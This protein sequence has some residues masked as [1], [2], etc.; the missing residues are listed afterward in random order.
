MLLAATPPDA[1]PATVLTQWPVNPLTIVPLVAAAWLYARGLRNVARAGAP[2]PS[3]T[4]LAFYAGIATVAIAL[5][6]P[7]DVYAQVSFSAHMAQHLLLTLLAPPLLA[8]GAPVTLALRA[9]RPETARLLARALRSRPVAFLFHPIVGWVLFVGMSFAI[10]FTGL[11]DS[12]L[13]SSPIHALEHSLWLGAALTFWWPIVGRDPSPHPVGFPARMLSMLL[14]M[15][16][17]SFLA[18]AIYSARSPLYPT[19]ALLPVPWGPRALADQRAAAAMMWLVG[20]LGMI[21]AML[22]VAAAWKRE[23]DAR[24]LRMEART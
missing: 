11:F 18:L 7:L 12:A 17:M 1:H 23:E 15:P 9:T 10:H 8:L 13:R 22:I 4:A 21:V 6:S 24:Q 3:R 19:Y 20:D 2:L 14:A 16:A 5:A